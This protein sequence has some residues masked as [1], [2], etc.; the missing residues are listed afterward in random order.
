MPLAPDQ[1]LL[2]K[3]KILK[4]LGSGAVGHVYLAEDMNLK[5][6]VSIKHLKPEY[7]KNEEALERFQREAQTIASL[8]HPNVAVVHGLEQEGD[9]NFIIIEYLNLFRDSLKW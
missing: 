2:G 5:R 7:A 4:H 6:R 8:R 1:I 9:E 3:Y